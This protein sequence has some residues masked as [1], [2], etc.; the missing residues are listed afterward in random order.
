VRYLPDQKN[1]APSQTVATA[2]IA[3]SYYGQVQQ[4]AHSAPDFIQKSFNFGGVVAKR[5]NTAEC[6]PNS[7]E[8]MLR[9]WRI[10]RERKHLREIGIIMSGVFAGLTSLLTPSQQ[11]NSIGVLRATSTAGTKVI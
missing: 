10:T 3:P 6:F 4:C 7:P 8:A 11:T 5:V 1:S 9:F 2:R